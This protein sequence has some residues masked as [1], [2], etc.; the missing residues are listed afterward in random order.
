MR[1]AQASL[2]LILA[3][4]AARSGGAFRA[5]APYAVLRDAGSAARHRH[6]LA[7]SLGLFARCVRRAKQPNAAGGGT[8]FVRAEAA[9][10]TWDE[11]NGDPPDA[12]DALLRSVAHHKIG[13][14]FVGTMPLDVPGPLASLVALA[15]FAPVIGRLL[16]H[17]FV[18]LEIHKDS[19]RA[20]EDGGQGEGMLMLCDF[21]PLDKTS[22]GTTLLLL[23]GGSVAARLRQRRL[24][25]LP[26]SVVLQG[27]GAADT[28]VQDV[29]EMHDAWECELSLLRNDCRSYAQALV[30][31][32]L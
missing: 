1:M 16:R 2:L 11:L 21:E 23:T 6:D 18:V 4:A 26:A 14:V 20:A 27:T 19:G 12:G 5:A 24:S 25:S 13:R 17:Y 31:A 8:L 22:A 15:A 9:P 29:V 3:A 28:T 10:L 32:L 7:G 30:Q